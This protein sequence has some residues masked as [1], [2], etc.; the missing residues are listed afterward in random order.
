MSKRDD[1]VNEVIRRVNKGMEKA[2]SFQGDG[3]VWGNWG[4]SLPA[5]HF[6]EGATD[7]ELIKPGLYDIELPMQIQY[8]C[9]LS[10]S[11]KVYTEGREKLKKLQTAMEL[12]ERLRKDGDGE[13][14]L[15]S[16]GMSIT[17]ITDILDNVLAVGVVYNLRYTDKFLGYE[18]FRH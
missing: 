4:R 10:D 14:L 17:E 15:I 8:I 7:H 11:R 3:G 12:D 9:R 5:L 18:S 2:Y 6:Y 1:I 13:E 16:Y